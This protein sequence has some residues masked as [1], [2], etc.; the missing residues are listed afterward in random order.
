M[1]GTALMLRTRSCAE[2]GN[3]SLY[4]YNKI[5]YDWMAGYGRA[6]AELL[7]VR[8]HW[9]LTNQNAVKSEAGRYI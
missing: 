5:S 8:S 1:L 4:L 6:T 2:T 9:T 3:A 7:P